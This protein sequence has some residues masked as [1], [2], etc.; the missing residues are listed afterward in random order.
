MS[1]KSGE[2]T[3]P[4]LGQAFKLMGQTPFLA[5]LGGELVEIGRERALTR[6]PYS[7]KLVG[8]PDTGVVHGGVITGLL[9]HTSGMAVMGVLREPMP[10]ATLDLRIDYMK[11]AVPGEDIVA[12][13]HCLKVGHDV[14][15][16]R[17]AAYQSDASNPVAICTGTFM[18]MRGQPAMI[19]PR[20]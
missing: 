16:V 19:P 8:D 1:E 6:V 2:S 7:L 14:A 15:F 18:L 9:D 11:P 4:W 10:I 17:G 12:E 13:C 3:A 5:S 20:E